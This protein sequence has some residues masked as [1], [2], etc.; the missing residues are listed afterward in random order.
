MNIR[1]VSGSRAAY[2]GIAFRLTPT[3]QKYYSF[4]VNE[5]QM[6]KVQR[7]IAADWFM[8]IAPR[9]GAGASPQRTNRIAI[10][11]EG[12]HYTFFVNDEY[13]G[14]TYDDQLTG[15]S[16]GVYIESNNPGEDTVFE[17]GDFDLRAP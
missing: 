6:L 9:S 16:V 11:G 8:L 10:H 3:P 12:S 14:E 2:Y 15:G 5:T 17:F 13:R 4:A 1:Q 7:L